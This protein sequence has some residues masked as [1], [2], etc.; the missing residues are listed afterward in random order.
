MSI[1]LSRLD[2]DGADRQSLI[3]F[4]TNNDFPFHVR[5][6]QW[7]VSQVE[8]M[9]DS[10]AF[11]SDDN[12]T[13]WLHDD[14]LGTL[15]CVRLEDLADDTPVFDLRLATEYRGRGLGASCLRAVTDHV[16]ATMNVDRFEGHTRDDNIAMRSTFL[17][18][19]WSKEAH[20]RRAWPVPGQTPKDSV[21]YAILREEWKFGASVDVHW[22]DL[23]MFPPQI[24]EDVEYTS[25]SVPEAGELL[26]LYRAVGWTAYTRDPASLHSS[27]MSSTHVVSARRDGELIGLAR[28]VSDFGSI[29]Y[30]QDV[31]VRPDH[32]TR[33]IG[34][35]L[36]TSVLKSF[37]GV[38]QKVL[39]TDTGPGQKRFYQSLGFSEVSESDGSEVRAFVKFR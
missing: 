24:E 39:L 19:G 3:G 2:P 21:A 31:L 18:A 12:D 1:S 20:Y 16:F 11:R 32:Q 25:N 10:G 9:I 36:V 29:V 33:G 23:P 26:E 5:S 6:E 28:A 4:F 30:L 13:F 22:H 37:V 14:N 7:P 27:V 17:R 35:E 38:R 8:E 34:R 15:G